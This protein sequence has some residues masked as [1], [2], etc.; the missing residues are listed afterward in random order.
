LC[1]SMG[2]GDLRSRMGAAVVAGGGALPRS[3]SSSF[4]SAPSSAGAHEHDGDVRFAE[5]GEEE[6]ETGYS[7]SDAH[8]AG[9]SHHDWAA[10][11]TPTVAP[12][13]SLPLRP[14]LKH[15]TGLVD[16]WYVADQP[17][18]KCEY[19]S[20]RTSLRVMRGRY[21]L[22]DNYAV[23]A[24]DGLPRTVLYDHYYDFCLQ[25]EQPRMNAAAFGNLVR[26]A[27]SSVRVRRLGRRGSSTY[28]YEGLGVRP[29]SALASRDDV[30]RTSLRRLRCVRHLRPPPPPPPMCVPPAPPL[31]WWGSRQTCAP[32]PGDG[33]PDGCVPDRHGAGHPAPRRGGGD[34]GGWAGHAQRQR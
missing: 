16:R 20:A 3:D 10:P 24:G 15:R 26:A 12:F 11:P 1:L 7:D 9:G 23:V 2:M 21:R 19:A 13:G 4:E 6:E 18:Q 27:F 14:T 22:R 28:Y 30:L 29:D 25:T 31:M 17:R 32:T 8:P 33:Y 5:E 34:G